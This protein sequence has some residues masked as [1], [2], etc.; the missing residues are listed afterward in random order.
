MREDRL[1]SL[2]GVIGQF[3]QKAQSTACRSPKQLSALLVEA[4]EADR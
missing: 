1:E 2:Q 3:I 4:L